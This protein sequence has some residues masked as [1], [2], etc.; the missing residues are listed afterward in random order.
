MFAAVGVAVVFADRLNGHDEERCCFYV[1]DAGGRDKTLRA[2]S[3]ELVRVE[4]DFFFGP[5]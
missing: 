1:V 5:P 4:W 2:E 3:A